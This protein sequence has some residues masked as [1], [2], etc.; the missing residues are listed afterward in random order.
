MA[1]SKKHKA[2]NSQWREKVLITLNLEYT[3]IGKNII[4]KGDIGN[5]NTLVDLLVSERIK[6]G[7]NP[8]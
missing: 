2:V 5:Y 4:F 7:I 6:L 3:I 8:Y 1:N